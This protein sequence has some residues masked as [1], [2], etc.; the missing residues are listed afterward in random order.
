[1]K[2]MVKFVLAHWIVG[3]IYVSGNKIERSIENDWS[4]CSFIEIKNLCF[5]ICWQ[6]PGFLNNERNE[7]FNE[8]PYKEKPVLDRI[9]MIINFASSWMDFRWCWNE[10]WIYI[11]LVNIVNVWKMEVFNF[12]TLKAFFICKFLTYNSSVV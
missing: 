8:I 6:K 11:S 10:D 12:N 9:I 1:M 5:N 4:D 3:K 7:K 2:P